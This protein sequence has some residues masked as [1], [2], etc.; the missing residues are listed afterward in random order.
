[1]EA[2][3]ST[4]A[5]ENTALLFP[6]EKELHYAELQNFPRKV[7]LDKSE[8]TVPAPVPAPGLRDEGRVSK[9]QC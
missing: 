1:M 8:E 4:V 7:P 5:R 6:Q 3:R 9:T 2:K